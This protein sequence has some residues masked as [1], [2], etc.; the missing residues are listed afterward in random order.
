VWVVGQRL[1]GRR[2]AVLTVLLLAVSPFAVR[3]AT[4]ARMYTLVI[5]LVLLGI[6]AFERALDDPRRPWPLAALFVL[7]GLL[8]L[9]HYWALFLSVAAAIAMVTRRVWTI[10]AAL[11]AGSVAFFI[12]WAPVFLYQST[13]TGTPWGAAP[14]LREVFGAIVNFSGG[15][16]DPGMYLSL[17]VLGLAVVAVY[18]RTGNGRGTI[19]LGWPGDRSATP[20]AAV[21]FGALFLGVLASLIART[22][23]APRYASVVLAPFLTLVALG[24]TKLPT[25]AAQLRATSACVV[26]SLGAIGFM[27]PV[28]RTEARLAAEAIAKFAAPGDVVVSCPD[29]IAVSLNRE[30]EKRPAVRA[31]DQVAYPVVTPV[32]RIDWV[33]Y[34]Q[35][36]KRADPAAFA[37]LVSQRAGSHR[38]FLAWAPSYR[39]FGDDCHTLLAD[40][41]V[42]RGTGNYVVHRRPR[43]YAEGMNVVALPA[44]SLPASFRAT[45]SA[46]P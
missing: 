7:A 35:R 4:E 9:T 5:F 19:E 39:T 8:V 28:Q 14:G 36:N 2:A 29:Q 3:Y 13:H 22:G 43:R 30:L 34:R 17:L 10:A 33:D 31:I 20:L 1:A 41:R 46:S 38:V 45:P 26:L 37:Q 24:I 11:A 18:G 15:V 16:T 12:P 23:F 32:D 27:L 6:L 42:A 40:L 21:T 25:Q 44:M